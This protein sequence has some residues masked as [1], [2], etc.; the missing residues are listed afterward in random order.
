MAASDNTKAFLA[1][2]WNEIAH[3]WNGQAPNPGKLGAIHV[4]ICKF[5]AE[6]DAKIDSQQL[7]IKMKDG[8]I[9]SLRRSIELK[10]AQM[11][12]AQI[13]LKDAQIHLSRVLVEGAHVSILCD[14]PVSPKDDSSDSFVHVTGCFNFMPCDFCL[15]Q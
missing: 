14:Q 10:N 2:I 6:K 13:H 7:E 8:V 15:N 11:K 12:E 5:V 9:A 1:N 3:V 4:D